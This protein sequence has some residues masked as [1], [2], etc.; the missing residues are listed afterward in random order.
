MHG[1]DP[2]P[3]DKNLLHNELSVYDVV[4]NKE[5]QLLKDAKEKG[6]NACG[7]LGMLLYQGVTAWELWIGK[8]AP[9]AVMRDALQLALQLTIDIS[10]YLR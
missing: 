2:S 9:V 1:N 4:Y 7:G 5:T 10:V 8:T 3:I 6:L